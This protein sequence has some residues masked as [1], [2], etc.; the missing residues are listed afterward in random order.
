[1]C[2]A[3]GVGVAEVCICVEFGAKLSVFDIIHYWCLLERGEIY[4]GLSFLTIYLVNERIV[5]A[6]FI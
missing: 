1:M 6:S 2:V 3:R 5:V 4:A